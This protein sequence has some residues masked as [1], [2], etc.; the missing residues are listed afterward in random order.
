MTKI[1]F[2]DFLHWVFPK[3]N[4][5]F[6]E[7][8]KEYHVEF[9]YLVPDQLFRNSRIIDM[10]HDHI[11]PDTYYRGFNLLNMIKVEM[12]KETNWYRWNKE[13]EN[14]YVLRL[15]GLIDWFYKTFEEEKP[16]HILI[17]GGLTYFARASA[18]VARELG[19]GII[20]VENS[21]I[22]G[23][24]FMDFTNGF[25]VN[26][27]EFA[28]CSQDWIDTR[29]LTKARE[30]ETD[31][32]ITDVFKNLKY[33]S[34]TT[35]PFPELKYKKS[36][37]VPL[38]VC[39]DQVCVYDSK[40]NN[41]QFIKEVLWLARNKFADWNIIFRCHP[42]EEKWP[43]H[44]YTGN[45]LVKQVLPDNVSVIRGS[46]ESISTQELLAKT[47]LVFV[48]NSQAG[49]EACLLGKPVVVFGDAFYGNK[50]FTLAYRRQ[51]NWESIKNDPQ[52]IVNLERMK[53]WFLYFYKWLYNKEFTE[54]D[55]KRIA[56]KLHLMK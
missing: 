9:K 18:E 31:K 34:K 30:K 50:G 40:Y 14:Q 2:C 45:W 21:F 8:L 7:L 36:V 49:L 39:G 23:K 35:Q 33:A 29:Y 51:H 46:F 56:Q 24:I 20:C 1:L 25:I 43:T 4:N 11:A 13:I 16:D 6:I 10:G 22:E 15:M 44:A 26:R 38:Q 47:D 53:L 52:Q 48:N 28:R 32:I 42:V 54:I 17:E 41:E 5:S 3:N 37:V 12:V 55:K 19:I 27:H